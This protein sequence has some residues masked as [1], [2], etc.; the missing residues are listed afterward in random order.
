MSRPNRRPFGA[1]ATSTARTRTKYL[2]GTASDRHWRR[3]SQTL[4]SLT[5]LVWLSS[6]TPLHAQSAS[7]ITRVWGA[8]GMGAG[9]AAGPYQGGGEV[10]GLG[11]IVVQRGKQRFSIRRVFVTDIWTFAVGDVGVLYGHTWRSERSPRSFSIS[12]GIARVGSDDC[13]YV[14][15]QFRCD[16]TIGLPL[17]AEVAWQPYRVV[18]LGLQGFGNIN[19]VSSFAA[20]AL[21]LQVGR[22][23]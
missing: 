9:Q 14:A 17:S 8:V 6:V 15:E 13:D 1:L 5:V 19:S 20:V 21:T 12:T 7:D 23:R 18:G 16:H 22:L 4:L 10:A 3:L 2:V 11:E